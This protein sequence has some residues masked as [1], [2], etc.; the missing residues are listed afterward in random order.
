M[1]SSSMFMFSANAT[2]ETRAGERGVNPFEQRKMLS[3]KGACDLGH[4]PRVVLWRSGSAASFFSAERT[5]SHRPKRI[6][7]SMS[8]VEARILKLRAAEKLLGMNNV[9][10]ESTAAAAKPK[11]KPAAVSHGIESPSFSFRMTAPGIE[12]KIGR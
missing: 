8:M 1:T 3:G 2:D 6:V 9:Q 12:Q 5:Q 4:I 10:R 11:Q 7:H